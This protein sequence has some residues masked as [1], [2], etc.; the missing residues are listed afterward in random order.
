[1][2]VQSLGGTCPLMLCDSGR[3]S[4]TLS[5]P[6]CQGCCCRFQALPRVGPRAGPSPL[7]TPT[8]SFT[9]FQGPCVICRRLR[10]LGRALSED[11]AACVSKTTGHLR[12]ELAHDGTCAVAAQIVETYSWSGSNPLLGGHCMLSSQNRGLSDKKQVGYWG[13]WVGSPRGVLPGS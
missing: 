11:R 9:A 5:A 8:P 13:I 10:C 1:M 12:Q 7:G 2:G 6:S 4:C 3:S